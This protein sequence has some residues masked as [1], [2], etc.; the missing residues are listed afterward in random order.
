MKRL[1]ENH[2]LDLQSSGLSDETI[3][4]NGYYTLSD[5]IRIAQILNWKSVR[6]ALRLGECLVFPFR[7][8]NGEFDGF[9]RLK[10]NRPRHGKGKYE[11]PAGEGSRAHYPLGVTELLCKP[12]FTILVTEGEKKAA[13]ATQVGCPCIGLC[14]VWAWTNGRDEHGERRLIHDL[15]QI[16]WRGANVGICFDRDERRNP[17]VSHALAELARTLHN[18]GANVHFIDLPLGPRGKDGRHEKQGIDDYIVRC[19]D[20]GA[21]FRDLVAEAIRPPSSAVALSDHRKHI[22]A[23][24]L[25]SI[26]KPGVYFDG[27]TMGTGKSFADIAACEMAGTSLIVLPTHE[28][29]NEVAEQLQRH[30]LDAVA[31]PP[32]NAENC[33]RFDE[34]EAVMA[35]GLVVSAALCASCPSENQCEYRTGT[36]EAEN[37]ACRIAT[38]KRVSLGNGSVLSG[39]KYISI[40]EDAVE[41]LRPIAVAMSGFAEV[42]EVAR[43]ASKEVRHNMD[44]R[45]Y[46]WR[47]EETANVIQ[48]QVAVAEKTG[49]LLLPG[50][51]GVVPAIDAVLYRGIRDSGISP[52]SEGMRIVRG[53]I[54]GGVRDVFVQVDT[55]LGDKGAKILHRS[56]MGVWQTKLPK[57]SAIWLND[58]T[59]DPRELALLLDASVRDLTPNGTTERRHAVE[60]VPAD[61]TKNAEPS[62]VIKTLLGV[63][64]RYPNADRIGVLTHKSHA[65]VARG[66]SRKGPKLPESIKRRIVHVGHFR[67]GGSR[68]S[69]TWLDKCDLIIVLGTPRVPAGA[70]R[71]RLLTTGRIGAATR[72][73]DWDRDYWAG[74]TMSGDRVTVMSRGYRDHDWHAGHRAIV[75]A[76]LQQAIGRGRGICEH[77]I[78]VVVVTTEELGERLVDWQF[79]PLTGTMMK[80]LCATVRL[81]EKACVPEQGRNGPELTAQNSNIYTLENC[82][83]SSTASALPTLTSSIAS[84]VGIKP[85]RTRELLSD[86]CAIGLVERVGQ[87]QGWRLTER[88]WSMA[89]PE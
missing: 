53:V 4:A 29:C 19:H 47:F 3:V 55:S 18:R 25:A 21:A 88:G 60:Q 57:R 83:V 33:L 2:R 9:A 75:A 89:R 41:T 17:Q 65:S 77:G 68:G 27:A 34:A 40:H 69:N 28:Q 74:I 45:H 8:I 67:S 20:R 39:R 49:R 16:D 7:G 30:G 58:A 15:D 86:L 32:L 81:A 10:P 48:E 13:S 59:G 56:A 76:E 31:Y 5:P 26:G 66:T 37:A 52:P 54:E 6:C 46:L 24:R 87:R 43:V 84:A 85:R 36:M 82:A 79:V 1:S 12:G 80:V 44:M 38:H 14:G 51:V 64:A 78:P 22:A 11:Q 35:C 50:A 71:T 61:L 62:T 63:I 73:G 23:A 70:I 42:A 72:D